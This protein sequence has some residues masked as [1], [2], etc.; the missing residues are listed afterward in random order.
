MGNFQLQMSFLC[1]FLTSFK[2][3]VATSFNNMLH[4]LTFLVPKIAAEET[5]QLQYAE[6]S[7]PFCFWT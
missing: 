4:D 3:A 6:T 7:G 2:A 1:V 5:C